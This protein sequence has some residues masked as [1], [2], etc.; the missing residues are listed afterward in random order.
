MNYF[1]LVLML[2]LSN[3]LCLSRR[4]RLKRE[5]VQAK[6]NPGHN[7]LELYNTLVQIQF[8]TSKTKLDIKYSKFGIQ[9]ASDLGS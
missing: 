7:I 6:C 2:C 9:V 4:L 8:T 3:V 1:I 5:Y